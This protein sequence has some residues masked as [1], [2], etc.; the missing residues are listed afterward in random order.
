M[1]I[2]HCFGN[3]IGSLGGQLVILLIMVKR[4][5]EENKW[6]TNIWPVQEGTEIQEFMALWEAIN[7]VKRDV[8]SEDQIL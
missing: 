2:R 4:G 1:A 7:D 8:A 6:I 3:P 5:L